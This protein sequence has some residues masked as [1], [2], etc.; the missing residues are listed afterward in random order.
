MHE[1]FRMEQ[2]SNNWRND[3]VTRM[4]RLFPRDTRSHTAGTTRHT[5]AKTKSEQESE[6]HL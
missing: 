5:D 2:F 4:D 3:S 1:M 6:M